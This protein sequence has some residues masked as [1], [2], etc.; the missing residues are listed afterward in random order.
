MTDV[1]EELKHLRDIRAY[2]AAQKERRDALLKSVTESPEYKTLGESLEVST[3][4][5]KELYDRI[6]GAAE[7]ESVLSNDKHPFPGVEVKWKKVFSY[8][9]QSAFEY[10]LHNMTGV[11]T[12]DTKR[13]EKAI[14]AGVVPEAIAQL[15]MEP[16]AYIAQDLSKFFPNEEEK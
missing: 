4:V 11:L 5:E 9:T 15:N 13:F 1:I 12:V 6:A 16:K 2:I 10:A 8:D 3:K 14:D 7:K